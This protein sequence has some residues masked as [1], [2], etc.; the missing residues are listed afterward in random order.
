MEIVLYISGMYVY[1]LILD[2]VCPL[3]KNVNPFCY[4]L[5]VCVC[6][7][8]CVCMYVCVFVVHARC[9]GGDGYV[10]ED[11]ERPGRHGYR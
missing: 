9:P 8:V 6:V 7:C 11:T 1:I 2:E 4:S 10:G 5:C 3:K